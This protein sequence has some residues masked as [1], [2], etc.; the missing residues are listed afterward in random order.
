MLGKISKEACIGAVIFLLAVTLVGAL[1]PGMVGGGENSEPVTMEEVSENVFRL[2]Y[3]V[4]SDG[5][6]E[7]VTIITQLIDQNGNRTIYAREQVEITET[8]GYETTLVI[9]LTG[10][11]LKEDE[12]PIIQVLVHRDGKTE[13]LFQHQFY[14]RPEKEFTTSWWQTLLALVPLVVVFIGILVFK[15]SSRYVAPVALIIFTIPIALLAFQEANV[16]ADMTKILIVVTYSVS[17]GLLD[18]VYSIFGAFFF[19]AVL[20]KAGALVYIKND[21][22]SISN[23]KQHL[24]LLIGFSFA[25]ILAVVAPAGSNF[26]IA[27]MMLLS[28]GFNRYGVGMLCLFG[29]SISSVYG[30]LGVAIVALAAV[31]E[32]DLLA[33]SGQIGLFMIF[34]TIL[35]PLWMNIIYTK[36]GLIK[37]LKDKDLREDIILLLAMGAVYA[38]VQFLTAYFLGPQLPTI[39]SGIATLMVIV[40]VEKTF[41]KHRVAKRMEQFAARKTRERKRDFTKRVLKMKSYYAP[42]MIMIVLL[43]FFQL[44]VPRVGPLDFA[45]GLADIPLNFTTI[46]KRVVF[47]ILKSPGTLVVLSTFTIPFFAKFWIPNNHE[48]NDICHDREEEDEEEDI[49]DFK[50]PNCDEH[51]NRTMKECP[52]CEEILVKDAEA[53]ALKKMEELEEED[54]HKQRVRSKQRHIVIDSFVHTLMTIIPILVSISSFIAV[55]NVMKY[56]NMTTSIAITLIDIIGGNEYIYVLFIPIIGMLGSGLTGST[57]TS[58]VLFGGLH[59]EAAAKLGLPKLKVAAAQVLGSTTGEMISPMNA[60]VVAAAVGLK[61]KESILIRRMLPSFF[62]WLAICIGTAFFFMYVF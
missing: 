1:I 3:K 22:K 16:L 55:A 57:T 30:L 4:F 26:V 53:Y 60:V 18:Y 15:L 29:N 5:P 11:E 46:N 7:N 28:L 49:H 14:E 21:F 24:I 23:D 52:I 19:L 33:V 9:N 32:L 45:F 27:A 6:I 2:D 47:N 25:M 34:L 12:H 10:V 50:C 31:T 44:V 8:T 62:T 37:D 51:V 42:F 20:K 41:L 36:K 61:D 48:V 40:V 56:F 58:N 38:I 43:L 35:T 59:M 54:Q 13:I 17:W 39:I